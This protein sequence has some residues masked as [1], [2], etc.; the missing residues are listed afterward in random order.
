ML[1]LEV[2]VG[3]LFAFSKSRGHETNVCGKKSYQPT[4][5]ALATRAIV[6]SEVAALMEGRVGKQ[7]RPGG[8]LLHTNL[9]HELLR[10][11]KKEKVG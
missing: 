3:E 4:I 9:E 2:L 6:I 11:A 8:S 7:Q 10:I 1:Q 5:D